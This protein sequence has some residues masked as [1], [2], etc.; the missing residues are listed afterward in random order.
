MHAFQIDSIAIFHQVK[1]CAVQATD[2]DNH[3]RSSVAEINH[4]EQI[5]KVTLETVV[6]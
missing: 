2:M 6:W 5:G 4:I 1:L 3:A